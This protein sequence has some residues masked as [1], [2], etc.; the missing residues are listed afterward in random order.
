[1]RLSRVASV[2]ACLAVL[3]VGLPATTQAGVLQPRAKAAGTPAQILRTVPAAAA[4][5]VGYKPG[6]FPVQN[7]MAKDSRGCTLR[8]QLLIKTAVKRPRVGAGCKLTGGTWSLDFGARTETN[9]AK[10]RVT[11]LIPD[12]YVYGQGGFMWNAKQRAAYSNYVASSAATRIGYRASSPAINSSSWAVTSMNGDGFVKKIYTTLVRTSDPTSAELDALKKQNPVLFEGWTLATL[13]NAKSWGISLSP[14]VYANFSVTINECSADPEKNNPCATTY[15]VPDVSA[16]NNVPALPA[17]VNEI[18]AVA[19]V[20]PDI[21][22]G[23]NQPA[24]GSPTNRALFGIHAP[25]HWDYDSIDEVDGPIDPNTIPSVPY[26]YVRLWDTE[27]TWR[28][29]EPTKGTFVWRKLDKQIQV[30][31]QK[32][33]HVMLV[34]GGTPEW[35]NGGGGPQTPPTNIDDWSN[36]VC[37]VAK[38]AGGSIAAFEIW[39]EANLATFWTGSPV[40]MADLTKAAFDAIRGCA[41]S[42]ALVVAANTTSRADG[43]FGT[44]FPAYLQELKARGWPVNAYSVHSYP[45]AAGGNGARIAGISQFRTMLA[46]AGAPFTTVF[47]TEVNYGMAGLGAGKEA[48]VG[49]DAGALLSRTYID[50]VRYGFGSTFWYV[51]TP[52]EDPKMG[53]QLT[54][55]ATS[56][57][58]AWNKTYEWLVGSQFHACGEVPEPAGLVVCQFDRGGEPFS[59]AWIGEVRSGASATVPK[60]FFQALGSKCDTLY[61]QD[62]SAI[63]SGQAPLTSTPVRIYGERLAAQDVPTRLVIRP[64]PFTIREDHGA[65]VSVSVSDAAGKALAGQTLRFICTGPLRFAFNSQELQVDTASNGTVDLDVYARK[66]SPG[67][68]T[69]EIQSI[70]NPHLKTTVP[71][72]VDRSTPTTTSRI[73][74][75]KFGINGPAEVG[76]LIGRYKG[77]QAGD[78]IKIARVRPGSEHDIIDKVL[79]ADGG[80]DVS[81]FPQGDSTYKVKITDASGNIRESKTLPPPTR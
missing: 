73:L 15:S 59:L 38:H 39:N 57:Q 35:A 68:A 41:G 54:P 79:A 52:Q 28:D 62:C 74:I 71:V 24:Y 64:Q 66:D 40:Q 48:I 76:R 77:R 25:A 45:K 33:A 22:Q 78:R 20:I 30:A 61:S 27:T 9:P 44:F 8:N 70:S 56:E 10:V 42:G 11:R 80:F 19:P 51:W 34:L 29:L 58:Q 32:D 4:L 13:L 18:S 67:I 6:S 43:S 17:A 14:S 7:P 49:E 65:V 2:V 53:I 26:G 36:Y 63:L 50:S 21:V 23:Y 37:T 3:A 1:M 69:I 12:V 55:G 16:E 47:D 5:R 72:T 60:G 81:F 46:L 75:T 31:Q